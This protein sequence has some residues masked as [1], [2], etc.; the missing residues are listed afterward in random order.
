MNSFHDLFVWRSIH[1]SPDVFCPFVCR[2]VTMLKTRMIW[3]HD[4]RKLPYGIFVFDTST[5]L[6]SHVIS[7]EYHLNIEEPIEPASTNLLI[8]SLTCWS[9]D[10]SLI[11]C[12]ILMHCPVTQNIFSWSLTGKL[13]NTSTGSRPSP[14]LASASYPS[15]TATFTLA[16]FTKLIL[17]A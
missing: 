2:L 4:D 1:V 5:Y 12:S 13:S 15:A 3:W 6:T 16:L 8:W 11:T 10:I 17:N 14:S 7:L 9:S